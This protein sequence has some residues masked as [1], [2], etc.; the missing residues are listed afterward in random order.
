[1]KDNNVKIYSSIVI[2]YV[3]LINKNINVHAFGYSFVIK[4]TIA[5]TQT[6]VYHSKITNVFAIAQK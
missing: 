6:N 4:Q 5:N 3:L 2:T 1:M